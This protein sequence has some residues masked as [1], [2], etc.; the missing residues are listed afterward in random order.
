MDWDWK[1]SFSFL[2]PEA[3]QEYPVLDIEGVDIDIYQIIFQPLIAAVS[4]RI[5]DDKELLSRLVMP[6]GLMTL[7]KCNRRFLE[8]V[9]KQNPKK[10]RLATLN[11][12]DTSRGRKE[13]VPTKWEPLFRVEGR[14]R[15]LIS[16][17]EPGIKVSGTLA[18]NPAEKLLII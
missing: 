3:I 15:L 9:S 1:K 8:N 2:I 10:K 7:D 4:F 14:L 18:G 5:Q 12:Y 11:R 6:G 13:I 16:S 17:S